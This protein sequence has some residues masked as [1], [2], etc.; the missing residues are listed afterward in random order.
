MVDEALRFA[1]DGRFVNRPYYCL[2]PKSPLPFPLSLGHLRFAFVGD[3]A[4]DVPKNFH[5]KEDKRTVPSSHGRFV[6]RPY[7]YLMPNA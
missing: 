5:Q 7:Y 6:N 4:L 2:M 1:F 3:G